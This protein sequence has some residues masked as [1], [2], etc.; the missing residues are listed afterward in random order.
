MASKKCSARRQDGE[1]CRQWAAR[2]GTVCRF[3][4]GAAK[5]VK[6]AAARRLAEEEARRQLELFGA[7][8]AVDPSQ[9][10]LD[11]VHWTAGEVEFWRSRVRELAIADQQALTWGETKIERGTDKGQPKDVTTA[12][13]KPHMYY[14]MLYAAQDR[15]SQYAT[16]ALRAGVEERR[17][18][19][20]EQQGDLV[21]MAIRRILAA[22]DLTPAQEALVTKVVPRELRAITDGAAA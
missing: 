10:L 9:A 2:G 6:A 12:E 4:G 3:H 13:S 21:A 22:L 17:V 1:P 5:Q 15:L 7:P 20:A 11:L 14:V 8:R 19:L 18:R 16:A